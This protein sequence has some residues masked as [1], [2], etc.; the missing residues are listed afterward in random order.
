MLV[1]IE[2]F[3]IPKKV[4]ELLKAGNP[5]VEHE[6]DSVDEEQNNVQDEFERCDDSDELDG[7]GIEHI[8]I[9]LP[10]YYYAD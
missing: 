7:S 9:D 10:A 3:P 4:L 2:N 6:D 5:T 1:C 8:D